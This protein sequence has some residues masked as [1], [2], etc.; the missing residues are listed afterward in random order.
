[1]GSREVDGESKLVSDWLECVDTASEDADAGLGRSIARKHSPVSKFQILSLRSRDTPNA[2]EMGE[3]WD[4]DEAREMSWVDE[5]ALAPWCRDEI[6]R[7]ENEGS[8]DRTEN[9]WG[10]RSSVSMSVSGCERDGGRVSLPVSLRLGD[11]G[12]AAH[13]TRP[14]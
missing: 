5:D 4:D 11:K 14:E 3:V 13:L 9:E 7:D 12:G 8:S 10:E 6:D 2:N 1:M